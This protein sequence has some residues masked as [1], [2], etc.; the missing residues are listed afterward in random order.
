MSMAKFDTAGVIYPE[1]LETMQ[2]VLDEIC[3]ERMI[4]KGIPEREKMALRLMALYGSGIRNPGELRVLLMRTP[5]AFVRRS[6]GRGH[7]A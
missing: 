4:G 2:S 1:D 5:Q 3:A 6:L 7:E